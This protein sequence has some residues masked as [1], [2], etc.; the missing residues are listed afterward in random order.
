MILRDAYLLLQTRMESGKVVVLYGPRR[1]GKT[2]LMR[3]YADEMAEIEHIKFVSGESDLVQRQLEDINK[4]K[5]QAFLGD[6]TLVCI[7]EAQNIPDVGKKLKFMVDFF[8]HIKFLVSGSASLEL[9]K[10]VG[11]PLVGRKWTIEIFPLSVHEIEQKYSHDAQTELLELELLYGMYP[12]VIQSHSLERKEAY[13]DE[14]LSSYLFKDILA[15]ENIRNSRK[16]RD[17]LTLLAFQIGSEVSVFELANQLNMNRVTVEKYLDLLEKTFVIKNI[18]GFS[19]NLRKEV[20]KTSRYYFLDNGIRNALIRNFNPISLRDDVG[21]LFENFMV[22]E[23]LKKQQ[24]RGP[25]ANSYF[26]RTYDQKEIDFLE[27]KSGK[28]YAYEFKWKPQSVKAPQEFLDTY[29]NTE[30]LCVHRDNYRDVL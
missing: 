15:L 13:L 14:I 10:N 5:I 23:L 20:T 3:M 16:I 2:T 27:E 1:V 19:R 28:I 8:P 9:A 22:I 21:K 17:L 7:D 30:F 24:N 26:W 18:R 29:P 12:E 6:Y 25:K 11:E 4:E